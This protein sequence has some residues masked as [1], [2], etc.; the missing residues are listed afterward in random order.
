MS[1]D[2]SHFQIFL[3]FNGIKFFAPA[4]YTPRVHLHRTVSYFRE[5]LDET[6]ELAKEII[7]IVHPEF[8]NTYNIVLK[9]LDAAPRHM[10]QLVQ[11]LL[12]FLKNLLLLEFIQLKLLLRGKGLQLLVP[13]KVL[14]VILKRKIIDVLI[15]QAWA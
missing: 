4:V 12:T 7:N 5:S 1:L 13:L 8:L 15:H 10:L 14:L 2:K 11:Q 6:M 9:N 3:V